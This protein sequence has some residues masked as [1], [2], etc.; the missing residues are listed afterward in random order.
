LLTKTGSLR[1]LSGVST[2]VVLSKAMEDLSNL[3]GQ[4]CAHMM[5]ENSSYA[6]NFES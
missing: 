3:R 2:P 1:S 4:K 5:L 6:K